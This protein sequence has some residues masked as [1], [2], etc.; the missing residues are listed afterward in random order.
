MPGSTAYKRKIRDVSQAL[1][2]R[3]FFSTTVSISVSG[4][5]WPTMPEVRVEGSESIRDGGMERY[6]QTNAGASGKTEG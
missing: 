4:A 3:R 1:L 2:R 5:V 6:N